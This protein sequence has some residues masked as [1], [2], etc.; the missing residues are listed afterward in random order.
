[1][2]TGQNSSSSGASHNI[3]MA[4]RKVLTT[5][6]GDDADMN[7]LTTWATWRDGTLTVSMQLTQAINRLVIPNVQRCGRGL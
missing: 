3:I 5:F 6:I 4:L 7:A 2:T 1:M